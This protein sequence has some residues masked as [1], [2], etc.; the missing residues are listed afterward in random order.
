MFAMC[1]KA[2]ILADRSFF[3]PTMT[4]ML[5]FPDEHLYAVYAPL[6]FPIA[7]PFILS[8]FRE[9]AIKRNKVI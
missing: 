7:V 2:S 5:Y 4:A 6:F 3:D 1:K 9:F 8:I